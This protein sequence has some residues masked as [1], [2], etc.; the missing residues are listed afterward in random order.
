MDQVVLRK[1]SPRVGRL[2]CSGNAADLLRDKKP[3]E[4][5]D[6]QPHHQ[7]DLCES[8]DRT[9]AC[10]I[11]ISHAICDGTSVPLLLRDLDMFYADAAA[12]VSPKPVY[13]DF[14]SQLQSTSAEE[15]AAYWRRYLENMETCNIP[16][17][18][19]SKTHRELRTL[20]LSL[21]GASDLR[22]FS[23]RNDITLS[24]ALQFVWSLVLSTFSGG[25]NVCFGYLS[26]GRDAP[27]DDIDDA[28]GLFI[29][30]MVCR[31]D[32]KPE[33]QITEAL[34]QIQDDHIQ[35]MGH[36]G[37]S[38]ADM[39]HEVGMTG[40]SFFNT[41]F[42]FQRRSQSENSKK[43]GFLF[44]ILEAHDP[45]EYDFTVNVEAYAEHIDV[46]FNYWTDY[47][48]PEQ[49]QN[50]SETFEGI[51]TS[52]TKSGNS[53]QVIGEI[54]PCS[55][56][57]RQQIMAWN[58]KPPPLVDNRVHDLIYRQSQNLP[59]TA[60]AIS[61]W[62]AELTYI[63][64]MSLS[65]RLSKHL[66]AN[67]ARPGTYV[68]ICFEKSSWAVVA[69][70]AVLN[71]GAAFVPIEASHP[72]GRIKFILENINA[73][74]VLCSPKH[75]EKFT[76]YE[77]IKP[78]VVDESLIQK[79]APSPEPQII[80]P[81]TTDPAY[82]IFT[83]GTTGLPKGTIISHRAFSTGATEHAPAILMRQHSRVLQFSNLCF[84]A[85][86]MEILTTLI[87]GA[88]ICIP[89]EEERMNNIPGAMSRMSVNWTL[90]TPSVA[91]VLKPESC[92]SLQV[93]VTGGEAMQARHIA[94]WQD[95]AA[96][97][98]AYGPSEAAVIATT[99]IKVDEKRR[100][101]NDD[102]SIIGRATG[103]RNWIVNPENH[104]LLMPI[105]SVGEL[106][107]EGNTLATGYL[108]NEE[109]TAK[110]FVP[111]P[112]WMI[113]PTYKVTQGQPKLMYKTG[114]LVRYSPE[115]N[116]V[117]C[118]RKDTQIKLNG[119]RIELG[120]I[121]YHVKQNLPDTIA[122]AVAMVAPA[123]Q[124]SAIAMFFVPQSQRERDDKMEEGQDV[125][126]ETT[127]LSI[128]ENDATICKALKKELASKIPT[129]M[130]PTLY[131]PITRIPCTTSGKL[132]QLK[133]G[134]L[135]AAKSKEDVVP[136]KLAQSSQKRRPASE[137]EKKL[138]ALWETI[139]SLEKGFATLDDS[140]FVLGGDS[141]QAM[142]L[143]AGARA[144]GI[145]ISTL[146]IFRTPTLWEMAEACGVLEDEEDSV[147]RPFGLL[148]EE[149]EL[150]QLLDEI[151]AQCKVEK[152]NVADAY[153]CSALQEGLITLSIKQPGAYVNQMVFRLPQELDL[154]QFK[155]A[156]QMA[157]D[158]IDILRTRVLHSASSTF[159]QVVLKEE[160]IDWQN[161][162]SREE[163]L[164][165]SSLLPESNGSKL[166]SF[167][168]VE[169][170]SSRDFIWSIH[171][172]LYDGWS[173]PNML[174]RVEELYFEDHSTSPKVSFAQ[175]ANYLSKVDGQAC[176]HFWKSKFEG[177][178]SVHFPKSTTPESQQGSTDTLKLSLNLP[179]RQA[180]TGITL[181]SI[182]RAAWA[183]VLFA[184][185]G[186]D[187]VVFGEVLTGRD[188]PVE[189]IID[190]LGPTLTTVPTR[191]RRDDES[192]VS[193][194]LQETSRMAAD[195][196]PF[197]HVG[198]QNIRRLSSDTSTACDFQ[199]LLVIQT[200]GE[201][202]PDTKIW[203][204]Q[205]E[206]VGSNFFTYPLV[207]ECNTGDANIMIDAHY[208]RNAISEWHVQTLL[209]QLESVLEKFC[210]EPA[211]SSLKLADVEIV[212]RQDIQSMEQWNNYELTEVDECI[213]ELFTK[214]AAAMPSTQA[215]CAWDGSFSYEE[216]KQ[217]SMDLAEHLKSIGVGSGTLVPFCMDKSCWAVVAQ[218][219]ILLAGGAIV[220]LDPAHPLSRHGEII[221]DTGAKIILC[222]PQYEKRYDETVKT[223]I[224]V[225]GQIRSR[226][227]PAGKH[228]F[229]R[230]ASS[231][232]P[233]YVI[234]TSGST[235]K[236]KGVV[237]EHRAF[238]SSSAAYSEAMLMD[239]R[240]RVFN[241]ASV[242][243]DVGL[244]E[245]LSPLTMGACACIPNNEA[246]MT[247]LAA[248]IDS[249]S[250]TWAFLTPSVAN[251]IEPSAV[252]SLKV[253]VCG[254]EAM[255]QDT[256]SKW[257][258][259]VTL[260]NGYGP[261]EASVIS[262]V[263][264]N[265]SKDRDA[266]SIGRAH[267]AGYTWITDANDYDRLAPLGCVGELL[268][269]GPLLARE[270][271]H[272]QQKTAAAF[273]E[274]PKWSS[275]AKNPTHAR[276]RLYRTGDL[277]KFNPDGTVVFLGRK[278]SQV[279]L[280]GQ[281][282][283]LGEIEHKFEI[284]PRIRHAVVLVPKS[285]LCKQRLVAV[286]SLAEFCEESKASGATQ[287]RLLQ[288]D[289][290]EP[291][292]KN[293]SE[294]KEALST[295][296]PPY[297]VP[298]MFVVLEAIPLLVSGKLD[299]KQVE[300]W[301]LN[302]DEANYNRLTG[303]ENDSSQDAPITE[304][305]QQLREIWAAVFNIPVEAVNPGQSFISQGGD[306][307]ISMSIIARCRKQ[308]ITL[309][310]QEILQSKSLHQVANLVE[311]R[312]HQSK[313][314]QLANLAEKVG[315]DF[316]L[317]PVQQLYFQLKGSSQDHT[318]EGRFNQS[319]L[320]GLRQRLSADKVKNAIALLVET[321]SMFRTRFSRSPS[322]NWQ[323]R[324]VSEVEASY[325]FQNPKVQDLKDL[326]SIQSAAQKALDIEKGPLFSATLVDVGA[327]TQVLCLIA[328][329]LIIDVVSWNIILAQLEELLTGAVSAIE[330]PLSF[331]VWSQMQKDHALSRDSKLVKD[332]LPFKVKRADM[333]FW[334][335]TQSSN[336]YGDVKH[337]NFTLGKASTRLLTGGAN[338]A[339]RTQPL[340]LFLAALISSF[341]STFPQRALPNV[342]N[343]THGRD[344]W[345]PTLDITGTTGWFTALYPI[346]V[347][348]E[349]NKKD[350]IDILK[351]VKDLRRSLP[352]NGRDYFAH[353]YLTPDGKW[354]FGDHMP[355]EI[356]LNYTGQAQ[357]GES[358]DSLFGPVNF[359]RSESDEQSMADVG[360]QTARMALIEISIGISGGET[361]FSIMYN[362]KMRYQDQIHNWIGKYQQA[363]E[364]TTAQLVKLS[365]QPTLSD[366]QLLPTN[367]SGLRKHVTET[368]RDIGI[369][370]LE[371]VEDMYL[372]APTQEGLLLSQI[373]NPEQYINYVISEAKLA[374]TSA[375]IDVQRLVRAWQKVV[376][377]HQSLR[378][379]FVYSV[380]KGHAF[381]Q[382]SLKQ[383][384]GGARVIQC[385]DEKFQEEFAKISLRE[386][387]KTRRPPLPH[388]LSICSTTSGRT[389]LKLE[390]NH[391]V[392][393]GGS[394]ALITR[395]LALAYE[396]RLPG[397]PKPLYSDYVKYIN[398]RAGDGSDINFWKEYLGGVQRTHLQ[399]IDPAPADDKRL[400]AVYL[401]FGRFAELGEFCRAND[402]T[403]SNVMLAAWGLVLRQYTGRDDVCFGNLTA[404][405]DAPVD[406]IQDTVGAF[407]NMLVCR[408]RFVD[409][410]NV[411]DLVRQLQ[412]DYLSMLP[413]QHCS[414]AKLQHD[415]GLTGEP[416]FNTAVSIQ[417][418]VSTRDA[419]KEGDAI[420]IE[421]LTDHDPTE[422][423]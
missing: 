28:V 176:N 72:E 276:R 188:I 200:A 172:A 146:D 171:H 385:G 271:L 217:H 94:K 374:E 52:L 108:K 283:E 46:L 78:I 75:Y 196:I 175:F 91:N 393:D 264:Q 157:V 213:H 101:I 139:L 277:A 379:A 272:D 57:Q 209:R 84:D 318:K 289:N 166:M 140:F 314:H 212:S 392:I 77:D 301:L 120:E 228:K 111:C 7:F 405:R 62:D 294:V 64:L 68:A 419:E 339:L 189:G 152:K 348:E 54:D 238:C 282:I 291:I 343:E 11:E 298:A 147:V 4:F 239:P 295:Q 32:C 128:A 236:P 401:H 330:K 37:S 381:D 290:M 13:R 41:A 398:D 263:N 10:M 313:P 103:C 153:P 143:V 150:D 387:N 376:D 286:V 55:K 380:C 80:S 420:E 367:Y 327:D 122:S 199:N 356:L 321:H 382:I 352:N 202:A 397:D 307:L 40:R 131:I 30:M 148:N 351:R 59:M 192:T 35:S 240:S 366:Y 346:N 403:L 61:S 232:D 107:L 87:V 207:V 194:Y 178:E 256:V 126:D 350:P 184:H 248:S 56:T 359:P 186:S 225:D 33:R 134:K 177:L 90:L 358:K 377:R 386:I 8:T 334:D 408:V 121:E 234:F 198:L 411:V 154:D 255:S 208:N 242:T 253:L 260:V 303:A 342:Y 306:S 371:E 18:G 402:I 113:D 100:L 34:S 320:L 310:L 12:A 268:L 362:S 265:V 404:G 169:D 47:I 133:L 142:K 309:S 145:A 215:V 129:Y 335:M 319:H 322:G 206:G 79:A 278:D 44:E 293:I 5:G 38:L 190:V 21:S 19:G 360:P 183:M 127:V 347:P 226:K 243:F 185:A 421:P 388:Q 160:I 104:N 369:S 406:G 85:S 20:T 99:G 112:D 195:V 106:V 237:V 164:A 331:Q 119:L 9:A 305:V 329:H 86:V 394:G 353:R 50:I 262:V 258:D 357:Q 281:R 161:F 26:S 95:G 399:K 174:Q 218:M 230:K 191:I 224:P 325:N 49:A 71:S 42:T 370:S 109:K 414:L 273:I 180:G 412:T 409:T 422:V 1:I 187:D 14:I 6:S 340:E 136:F 326:V 2:Q 193:Q 267:S 51:V 266:S 332:V 250:A 114:D 211:D 244:M 216:L 165:G 181:P 48:C 221:H 375:R 214:Q 76:Q 17:I 365:P 163:A 257:A 233:A 219:G 390:L 259:A 223:V 65:K 341:A 395:D 29:S 368:F 415:L 378:T 416:L 98:N 167:A 96:L 296:L 74:L 361:H 324:V 384:K 328:H 323:Q 285:G 338:S 251:L 125:G 60:P 110:A 304:T 53:L 363:M 83:S 158:E 287:C 92:P 117:Y 36:Q 275:G 345:D 349:C 144:E 288:Q 43:H 297:M 93:L 316:D 333:A 292:Q 284:N 315:E 155:M 241:F 413:H 69:L 317:S 336:C 123:G 149:G 173:M 151:T 89:S 73:K 3:L 137:A 66:A 391:A 130:I 308:G 204:P 270:Y 364:A 124:E 311:S 162:N 396:G 227:T 407:I 24:T 252:P 67:G 235:G 400:N 231:S 141:V 269:E 299:R 156:W 372:C 389:Y 274:N 229:H 418:Q 179:S 81:K 70:L 39:Q 115:G 210:N 417:N 201:A 116:I 170:A 249:L 261:T 88:C 102:P 27:V 135:I 97:V 302:I 383:A 58:E 105:G 203:D 118:A 22:D 132:D 159:L 254:G 182:I 45:S 168:L 25:K 344:V 63:K 245:N 354:R 82:L 197:Q 279:K 138:A 23:A 205:N 15:N 373:R 337:E 16:S 410:T 312:G 222:S 355:M 220:P 423:S 246:K 280:H 31:L 300:R 247:N